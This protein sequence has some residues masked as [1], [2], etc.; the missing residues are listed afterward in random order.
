M[1]AVQLPKRQQSATTIEANQAGAD[2]AAGWRVQ[3]WSKEGTRS[4]I[5]KKARES[6]L[7]ISQTFTG[8]SQYNARCVPS[9]IFAHDTSAELAS[10]VAALPERRRAV[11]NLRKGIF[12]QRWFAPA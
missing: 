3:K 1:V 4:I 8:F 5:K 6:S 9:Y 10:V 7:A 12:I 2:G 11:L